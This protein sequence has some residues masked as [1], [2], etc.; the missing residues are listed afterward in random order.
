MTPDEL[1]ALV[2]A[3]RHLITQ[4]PGFEAI[5][6][7]TRTDWIDPDTRSKRKVQLKPRGAWMTPARLEAYKAKK[8]RNRQAKKMLREEWPVR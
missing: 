2:E 8:E 7:K 1:A 5:K 3:N 6:P 4:V